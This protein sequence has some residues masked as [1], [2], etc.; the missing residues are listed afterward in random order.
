MKL[1]PRGWPAA[2]SFLFSTGLGLGLALAA[3]C[4][5]GVVSSGESSDL[6]L[7]GELSLFTTETPRTAADADAR[8]VELGV[9]LRSAEP[10]R[11]TGIRFF[12]ASGQSGAKTGHLWSA[13]G[14]LLAKVRFTTETASGWQTARLAH[15]VA[16]T[17]DTVYVVSYFTPAGHYPST[18]DYFAAAG[19]TV[20]PLQ[21]L[22]D[23]ES[24]GNGVYHYGTAAAFPTS[25]YRATN[26]FV[27]V[28][29]APDSSM[30]G[31]GTGLRGEYFNSANLSGTSVQRLDGT[32]NFDWASGRPMTGIAADNFSVRWTGQVLAPLAGSY[33]FQTV[34][35]D[36]VRLRVN[37]KLLVD[38]WTD[39]GKTT[40]SGTLTLTAGS[41]NAIELEYY[42]RGGLAVMQ[43]GWTPP[44]GTAAIIPTASLFPGTSAPPPSVDA[45]TPPP[46]SDAGTVL[47]LP[48]IPWEGGSA[49][50]AR[51]AKASAAGWSAPSFFPIS[52]FLGKPEHAARLK[53]LGVNTLMG[54]EHDGSSMASITRT[55]IFVMPQN[56]WTPAEVGNDPSVVAWTV[57]D[58][59]DMGLG[60]PGAN[61]DENLA[62]QRSYVAQVRSYNDG[63]F[64]FANYGNGLLHTWWAIHTMDELMQIVDVASVDK[65]FYTSP[66]IWGITPDSPYWPTGAKVSSSGAY[67]WLADQMA[68]YQNP[69][70]IH[71]SWI[72]VEVARP[73]LTED[74]SLVIKPEQIEG[75]VWS[76]IIHEARGIAYFQ[77]SNDPSCSG[78]ALI[79]CD[80]ARQ[81]KVKA[82]NSKIQSLAPV[83]NTQSYRYDFGAGVDTMFKVYDGSAYVFADIGLLQG[84][85]TK[86][87]K[88]PPEIK[89]TSAT[90]V[91][92]SRSVPVVNGS[93]TDTFSSEYTHHVYAIPL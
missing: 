73:Y 64:A 53:A 56:E 33:Q 35:D 86:T 26:Y 92:E 20:V 29:F 23:G 72:F 75:A 60:C 55:G 48:R 82:V 93:F 70:S 74:G 83:L 38:N 63:R 36:G 50:Y 11:V 45:G 43:L 6:N 30:Q 66:H 58:E 52:V 89:G 65:Y 51:F 81:D 85:G 77:H 90:V 21:A 17:A 22:K 9:K 40:N 5:K 18:T 44:G 10:G 34:S 37:G 67:G 27:D 24:G 49:Y 2:R 25:T 3:G 80:S 91:G 19:H 16:I 46:P 13:A 8:G 87:F 78:Y 1:K 12:K 31:G 62:A 79:D 14:E 15:P 4:G 28:L 61:D 42:E 76:A 47:A 59:C 7:S 39:H 69:A 71:P 57:S 32:V 84:P 54:A 68:R 88:L 41:K